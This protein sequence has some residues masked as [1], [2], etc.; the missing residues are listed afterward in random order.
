MQRVL[1]LAGVTALGLLA[2]APVSAQQMAQAQ[3]TARA[4]QKAPASPAQAEPGA[5][6]ADAEIAELRKR[7]NVTAAQQPQFDALAAVI[8]QNTQEMNANMPPQNRAMSAVD[9]MKTA[10]QLAQH[11]ADSLNRLLPPLQA[12]YDTLSPE[13]KKVADQ[14]FGEQDAGPPPPQAPAK[15]R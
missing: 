8:R 1:M 13:Q 12:L 14:F 4:A 2:F 9:S 10:Q 11:E 6:N 3:G 5:P 7:L 15:R